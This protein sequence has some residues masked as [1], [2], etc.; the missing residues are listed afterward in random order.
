[1]RDIE[2][3]VHHIN[4]EFNLTSSNKWVT[5]GC[6]YPG[7]LAALARVKFPELIHSAFASSAPIRFKPDNY[8]YSEVLSRVIDS[9]NQSCTAQVDRAHQDLY[10]L[11]KNFQGRK[12]IRQLFK[13]ISSLLKILSI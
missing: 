10:R 1:M 5:I 6:S 11:I 7:S 2:A 12:F 3:F 9:Y 13:Y 8:E 4:Q